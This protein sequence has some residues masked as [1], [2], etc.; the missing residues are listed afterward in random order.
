MNVQK[1]D[2]KKPYCFSSTI[3]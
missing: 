3:Q 2:K 1:N